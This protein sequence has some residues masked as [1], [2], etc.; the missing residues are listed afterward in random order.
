MIGLRFGWMLG[1]TVLVETV[2]DWPGVGLYAVDAVKNSDF[3]PIMGVT[4]VLG[5]FFMLTNFLI[6]M[7]YAVLDPR[8]RNQV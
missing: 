4:I 3:E 8:V 6:D 2:F 7:A 1:G 5:F